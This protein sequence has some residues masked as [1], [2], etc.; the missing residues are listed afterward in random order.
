[1]S[2]VNVGS[3]NIDR[4]F[5][6]GHLARPGETIAASSF[7]LFAG[8]KGANQSV[9]LARAG[10]RVMHVG[11]VG[12]DGAWLVEALAREGVDTRHV[13]VGDAPTGQA[14]I[15]VDDAGENAIV[16]A[17]G[18]NHELTPALITQALDAAPGG[19]W[20]LLQNETSS[21][22][23][24]IRLAH[25]RGMRVAF[26]PAPMDER[27]REYPLE[28]VHLLCV[29]QTEGAALAGRQSAEAIMAQL[30]HRLG[31][32][33]I[34]LTLGSAGARYHCAH[35]ELHEAPPAVEGV[36]TTAAGD[37]FLGYFL[38]G[39]AA[40]VDPP[41]CLRRACRAAALCVTRPGA[42]ESIPKADEVDR[43]G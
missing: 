21:V 32:C 15:Q 35:G 5:R 24:A 41:A 17:A 3:L 4:V 1:M 14:I 19:A 10:A 30:V 40:G 33:E 34:L 20:L 29:N 25:R 8:G 22:A 39:R 37:T 27:V 38:A 11:R 18:A 43:L 36:D 23:E 42:I 28:L 26:N 31:E 7:A 12:A 6:V 2:V 16:L 9:A 13:G